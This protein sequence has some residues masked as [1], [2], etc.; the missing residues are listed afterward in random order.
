MTR[1]IRRWLGDSVEYGIGQYSGRLDEIEEMGPALRDLDDD[2]LRLRA[3]ELRDRAHRGDDP[4]SLAA[5]CFAMVREV[6]HRTIGLRPYDE[7]LFASLALSNGAVIEMQTGEGKTLAAVAPVALAALT[8]G[9]AHVLTFNDYLARRD[10]LWMG[11]VY[12]Y[13][14]LS[15]G[16]VQED[17]VFE[18]RQRAYECDITYITAKEAGFD[19]LR[20][21][22][23]LDSSMLLRRE[24]AF[25][26][27]DEADSILIDEAR[28]PLVIAGMV[29]GEENSARQ[30]ATLALQLRDGVDFDTDEYGHNIFLTEAGSAR[31]EASLGCGNL[32]DSENLGLLADLRNAIHALHLVKRDRD[33]IVRGGRVELVD[34]FTGRV[35]EKRQWPDGLQAAIE[36]KEELVLQDEGRI[37]GS[38]T[39]HHFL[40]TYPRLCGMTA[41]AASSAKELGDFYDLSVV[42]VPAHRPCVRVDHEDVIFTHPEAKMRALVDE[43]T[44]VRTTVI[45]VLVGTASVA[46]SEELAALLVT[47]GVPCRVLNA[48]NDELE[49]GIIAEA[50]APGAVTIST[51]M[52]GRGTDIKLGGADERDRDLVV[53]LGGLYVIGTNRHESL[54]IDR[55][56]RGRAGRQGD[57]GSSRFFVSLDDPLITRYG[58]DKLIG[59]RALPDQQDGAVDSPILAYEIAR[60][61][62]IMEGEAFDIRRRLWE[63]SAVIE[64]QR[65]SL[66]DRR[67]RI[68]LGE[69]RLDLLSR[70]RRERWTALSETLGVDPAEEIEKRLTLLV[71]DRCWS[72]HLAELSRIRDGIHVVSY[73][74][75]D[76]ASE[77]CRE[78]AQAYS[79]LQESVD[80]E[81]V[82][83]F[84]KIEIGPDGVDWEALSLV[85]PSSTWTYQV[86]DTPFGGNTMQGLA[87][88]TGTAALGAIAAG[89]FLFI[90]GLVLHWKRRKLKA[91]MEKRDS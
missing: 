21:F 65:T 26:L 43:I 46:E 60:A 69:E 33:Y 20:S 15:V 68:L 16:V 51:N 3:R 75:K 8:G 5:D 19:F 17:S 82:D 48:K 50:G 52:A 89:P 35:A 27:V 49:A 84:D 63:F 71:T 62:R 70:C 78:A 29:E 80:D 38:I 32:Y 44:E 53:E 81:I 73:V 6:A 45:P 66:Q 7:Q 40:R 42:V 1:R 87:N 64:S 76:P 34:E 31:V 72:D 58:V 39:M 67:Q 36:A 37:L 85:G 86:S 56:L 14:G 74:G 24:A 83:L 23:C 9:G 12:E 47:S 25:A 88:R 57:P 61:Q 55:Q 90:W 59:A 11:P 77:F 2:G 10:A 91:E 28:I 41:T 13:L 54:R 4:E 30:A 79:D 22:L 18:D